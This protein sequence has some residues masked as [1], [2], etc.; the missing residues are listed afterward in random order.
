MIIKGYS[1]GYRQ[2]CGFKT[3]PRRSFMACPITLATCSELAE[4]GYMMLFVLYTPVCFVSWMNMVLHYLP[5]MRVF[6]GR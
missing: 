5:T 6:F 1:I 4:L 2:L 3:L